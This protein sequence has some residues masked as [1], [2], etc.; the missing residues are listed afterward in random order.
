MTDISSLNES[1]DQSSLTFYTGELPADEG[2]VEAGHE[3]NGYFW[4]GIAAFL[5]PDLAARLELD[6]EAG[7]FAA[8]GSVEDLTALRTALEPVLASPQLVVDLLARASA[9]GFQFDD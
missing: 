2:V 5:Q 4:E 9:V 1:A 7:M 3:P 8:Y 6:S